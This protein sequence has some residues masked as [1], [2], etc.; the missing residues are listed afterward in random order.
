VKR[1]S[2]NLLNSLEI[3]DIRIGGLRRYSGR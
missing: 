1:I 2:L 3:V